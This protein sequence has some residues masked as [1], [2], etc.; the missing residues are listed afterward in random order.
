MFLYAILIFDTLKKHNIT[1]ELFIMECLR[2]MLFTRVLDLIKIV[3]KCP[4]KSVNNL[5]INEFILTVEMFCRVGLLS[6]VNLCNS[7]FR[8]L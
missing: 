6:G 5:I 2:R 4:H 3:H 1:F 7:A 8:K